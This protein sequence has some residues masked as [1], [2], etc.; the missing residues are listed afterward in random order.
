MDEDDGELVSE[1][2]VSWLDKNNSVFKWPDEKYA[3]LY[4][5]TKV[6]LHD[7]IGRNIPLK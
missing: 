6:S 7:R 1:V 5:K 4:I 3:G 2:P